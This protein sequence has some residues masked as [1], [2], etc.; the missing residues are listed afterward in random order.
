MFS[1]NAVFAMG[2]EYS[3]ELGDELVD[4]G[5]QLG[6]LPAVGLAAAPHQEIKLDRNVYTFSLEDRSW[7]LHSNMLT[8]RQ[9]QLTTIRYLLF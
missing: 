5:P 7:T 9:A 1:E 3:V 6:I 8:P 2:G 4:P